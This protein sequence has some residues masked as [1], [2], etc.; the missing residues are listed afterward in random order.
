[1]HT[2]NMSKKLLDSWYRERQK[3][4]MLLKEKDPKISREI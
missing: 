2:D 1:M 3:F 4:T